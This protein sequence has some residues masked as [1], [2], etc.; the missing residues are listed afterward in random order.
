MKRVISIALVILLVA[1]L[2][3]GCSGNGV[4]GT[5]RLKTING[6]DVGEFFNTFIAAFGG[7]NVDFK[8]EDL[9]VM[10]LKDD[11]KVE[12][13]SHLDDEAETLEGTWKQEGDKVII[14]LQDEAQEFTLKDGS[15]VI[16]QD[17]MSM[18]LSK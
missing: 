9:M 18:V 1:S 3:V 6:M 15:L 17:G 16:E 7:E 14:T 4:T 8:A 12:V 5:Y 13:S 10:T 11:G 2:F